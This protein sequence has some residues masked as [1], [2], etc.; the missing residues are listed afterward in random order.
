MSLLPDEPPR[1]FRRPRISIWFL[2]SGK[3]R[4]RF[5]SQ[6]G[7]ARSS[8]IAAEGSRSE[9]WEVLGVGL[10]L[11]S[12]S[13]TTSSRRKSVDLEGK[14]GIDRDF[15]SKA[16]KKGEDVVQLSW[17]NAAPNALYESRGSKIVWC[18]R[19]DFCCYTELFTCGSRD[20]C[21]SPGIVQP[22]GQLNDK[23]P[24]ERSPR[25]SIWK[26]DGPY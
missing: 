2:F 18:G 17:R 16:E 3:P 7:Q 9:S 12:T 25:Q 11:S 1:L 24:P 19:Q 13:W 23:S 22:S 5:S 26:A 14:K 21:L 4:S 15:F 10:T 6:Q 8:T 20:I